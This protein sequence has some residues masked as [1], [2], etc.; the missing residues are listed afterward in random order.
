MV[1]ATTDGTD[2]M[3]WLVQ[4]EPFSVEVRTQILAWRADGT[5]LNFVTEASSVDR[6]DDWFLSVDVA[7]RT[8]SWLLSVRFPPCSDQNEVSFASGSWEVIAV[9][10]TGM[11]EVELPGE[12][13][14]PPRLTITCRTIDG[15]LTAIDSRLLEPGEFAAG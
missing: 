13:P 12:P 2:S 1:T 4:Q 5:A 15:A 3:G 14:E 10:D 8:G 11:V 6:R 9:A 7:D